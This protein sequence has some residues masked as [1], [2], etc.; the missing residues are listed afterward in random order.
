MRTAVKINSDGG[1]RE[2]CSV[3]FRKCDL[4]NVCD[5]CTISVKCVK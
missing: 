4:L 5:I 3:T 2:G 1:Q